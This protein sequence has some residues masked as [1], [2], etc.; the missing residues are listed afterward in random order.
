MAWVE[1]ASIFKLTPYLTELSFGHKSEGIQH[2]FQMKSQLDVV[3][4]FYLFIQ[5]PQMLMNRTQMERLSELRDTD[6]RRWLSLCDCEYVCSLLISLLWQP[7]WQGANMTV[8]VSPLSPDIDIWPLKGNRS[9]FR[10]TWCLHRWQEAQ[11]LRAQIQ[12]VVMLRDLFL[13]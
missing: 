10:I 11:R 8:H 13:H 4:I 7:G 5:S 3:V 1:V 6:L 9:N 2:S 12:C